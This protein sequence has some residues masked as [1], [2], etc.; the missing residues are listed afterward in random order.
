M[1]TSMLARSTPRRLWVWLPNTVKFLATSAT[2]SLSSPRTSPVSATY[3]TVLLSWF[4]TV[5]ADG[6]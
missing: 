3:Q 2:F 4:P 1:G 6:I 5:T